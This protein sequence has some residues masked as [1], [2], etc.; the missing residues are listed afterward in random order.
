MGNELGNCFLRI[1]NATAVVNFAL[2][3]LESIVFI[4]KCE[5]NGIVKAY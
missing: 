4:Y 3:C 5:K 1:N 2:Y